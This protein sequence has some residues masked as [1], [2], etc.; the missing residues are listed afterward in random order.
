[1]TAASRNLFED[2]EGRSEPCGGS[3][4]D[5]AERSCDASARGESGG[6]CTDPERGGERPGAPSGRVW[7]RRVGCWVGIVTS[8][9]STQPLPLLA[10]A[11]TL[12]SPTGRS[13]ADGSN[14]DGVL[15]SIGHRL[16]EFAEMWCV[17]WGLV[18]ACKSERTEGCP[19][20]NAV[21]PLIL[22]ALS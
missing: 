8:V 18:S 16:V 7:S 11:L 5:T 22:T 17:S 20:C 3:V 12:P 10:M 14:R 6:I 2:D 9:H 1:M 19:L 13:A 15:V 21:S 4:L